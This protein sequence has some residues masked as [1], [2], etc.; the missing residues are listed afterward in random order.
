MTQ[1]DV[2][3]FL[4]SF[5]KFSDELSNGEET[6]NK[7]MN[8][9]VTFSIGYALKDM[10]ENAAST[11]RRI[12]NRA[13]H[14]DEDEEDE[15]EVDTLELI[16]MQIILNATV[17]EFDDELGNRVFKDMIAA[18]LSIDLSQIEVIEV[19]KD[20]GLKVD[21]EI[22]KADTGLHDV[23]ESLSRMI[24]NNIIDFGFKVIEASYPA[25]DPA[26][27]RQYLIRDGYRIVREEDQINWLN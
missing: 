10:N 2:F 4:Y 20:T 14:D 16:V 5:K 19:V 21:F 13:G 3:G 12:L 6:C 15:E 17:D 22:T 18:A 9:N 1:I 11:G 24:R 26:K 8:P 25:S 23:K 27:Q 7:I